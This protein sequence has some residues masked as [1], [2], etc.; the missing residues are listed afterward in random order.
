MR[1]A[2]F[3]FDGTL[4]SNETYQLLMN[5]LKEHPIYHARYKR[6]MRLVLPPYIGSKMK[7]YP[8]QKM[9]NRSMQVYLEALKGL[10]VAELDEYFEEVADKMHVDLNKEVV[11]KLYEH[12]KDGIHIM[13]VSGAYSPLLHMVTKN[14]PVD[15]IIGTDVP[16]NQKI[17][18][19]NTQL[20]H[21][22]GTRKNEQIEQALAGK[23]I[24]WENSYAY[25]DSLSDITVLELVGHPVAVQPDKKLQTIAIKREW[26]II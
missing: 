2:I 20:N 12:A 6:F 24:D 1:V 9:R 8:R 25:A 19:T 18:N 17:V 10:T 3:D 7:V 21:I 26:A 23:E 14:M 5:H 22:Q 4:Y 11:D 16:V 15:T 13:V